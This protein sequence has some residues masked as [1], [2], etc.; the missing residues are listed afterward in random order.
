MLSDIMSPVRPIHG[1]GSLDPVDRHDNNTM[2]CS[3]HEAVWTRRS[4][5]RSFTLF[6]LERLFCDEELLVN[7]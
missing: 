7:V 5:A 2:F 6:T 1:H 3:S 4:F